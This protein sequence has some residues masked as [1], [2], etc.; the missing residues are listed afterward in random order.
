M[1][2][3][4]ATLLEDCCLSAEPALG[5]E[6]S[7]LRYLPGSAV[8]GMFAKAYLDAGKPANAKFRSFFCEDLISFPCLY[9]DDGFQPLP[10]SAFTCKIYGGFLADQKQFGKKECHGVYD[11]LFED[12]PHI[13]LSINSRACPNSTCG[14]APLKKMESAFYQK[15]AGELLSPN[16]KTRLQMRTAISQKQQT[17]L[18]GSL[19]SMEEI[20]A[21]TTFRGTFISAHSDLLGELLQQVP[22]SFF[23]WTGKRGA[24]KVEIKIESTGEPEPIPYFFSVLQNAGKAY[25]ALTLTCDTM[26]LDHRL[27]SVQFL[28][29]NILKDPDQVGF[30]QDVAVAIE[31]AF[32]ATRRISGWNTVSRIF[33]ADDLALVAGSTFLLSIYESDQGKV[34]TWMRTVL[35]TGI[36]VR[37]SEGFG[38]VRFDDPLHVAACRDPQKIGG[39]L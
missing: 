27:R 22:A 20:P 37:R 6:L 25:F 39:P 4:K 23:A 35:E 31:K 26:L 24:G 18:E 15:K 2:E 7:T 29:E 12:L 16:F 34:E 3:I 36:G 17:A 1:I 14:H 33:K 10:L 8:R 9:P 28:S 21:G 19:H 38:R 13:H 5:N 30:P 11:L 32:C